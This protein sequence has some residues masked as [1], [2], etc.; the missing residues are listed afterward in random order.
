MN[1]VPDSH[2]NQGCRMHWPMSQMGRPRPQGTGDLPTATWLGERGQRDL[3]PDISVDSLTVESQRPHPFFSYFRKASKA[4]LD[5]FLPFGKQAKLA[6]Y[7][8]SVP[9]PLWG[10]PLLFSAGPCIQCPR[11]VTKTLQ[12]ASHVCVL[13][14]PATHSSLSRQSRTEFITVQLASVSSLTTDHRAESQH[15]VQYMS[16][17]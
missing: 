16:E 8:E 2:S 1:N 6:H 3:N 17:S 9:S 13:K 11:S 14:P 5:I 10:C 7:F 15:P 4:F 12:D